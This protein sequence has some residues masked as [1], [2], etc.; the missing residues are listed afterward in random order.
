[1]TVL[2]MHNEFRLLLDKADGGASPS[3][4]NAEIDTLLNIAQDK[5]IAKRAFGNN[6]RRT[7]FE[8]D[9]KRRDDLRGVVWYKKLGPSSMVVDADKPNSK[10]VELPSSYR[11]MLS[12]QAMISYT[13]DGNI[14]SKRVGVKPI[15]HDRLNKIMDDPFNKPTNDTVYRLDVGPPSGESTVKRYVELLTASGTQINE[16]YIRYIMNPDQIASPN[17]LASVSGTSCKLAEHTH[18]EIVRMAVLEALENIESPRYQSSK[19][20]LNEIE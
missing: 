8:E 19:I 12:E 13:K 14:I 3:F 20:E 10:I 7:S 9:Q 16:Y 1:M 11:H 15:A 6:I 4:L 18:R 5:F 2:E 17:S